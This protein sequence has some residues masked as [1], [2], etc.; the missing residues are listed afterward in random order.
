MRWRKCWLWVRNVR[1]I[2]RPAFVGAQPV[3]YKASLGTDQHHP[4]IK[5]SEQTSS[6]TSTLY[7]IHHKT[8]QKM[9]KCELCDGQGIPGTTCPTCGHDPKK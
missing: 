2:I 1:T 8:T 7:F 5:A 9:S 3:R 6:T 4:C